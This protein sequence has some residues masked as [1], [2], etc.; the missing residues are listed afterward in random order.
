MEPKRFLLEGP[1]LQGLQERV[2]FEHGAGATIVAAERVTVGGIRGFFA[3]Q[4]YEVTVE[5]L[6]PRPRA[7]HARLDLPARLGIAALLD[8]A[9]EVEARIHGQAPEPSLSTTS[10]G[11]AALMD[12]LTFATGR[13]QQ[14]PADEPAMPAAPEPARP[15]LVAPATFGAPGDLVLLVGM[16]DD[17]LTAARSMIA[18]IVDAEFRVAGALQVAGVERLDDRRS[19]QAARALGVSRGTSVFVAFGLGPEPFDA[20]DRA[21]A[22]KAVGAD[23][24]WVIVDA[25]RKA[26]DTIRWVNAVASAVRVDAVAGLGQELTTTPTTVEDLGLPVRWLVAAAPAERT[27]RRAARELHRLPR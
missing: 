18:E 2:Q 12:E 8:D 7:A 5:V 25:G 1:T 17:T 3:R 10:P 13:V 15:P 4:H 22:L 20:G 11:F 23:Q 21:A 16:Q 14:P 6:L 19:A 24:V 9:D 27:G 26:A